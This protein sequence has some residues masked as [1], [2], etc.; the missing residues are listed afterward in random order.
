[1]IV[2]GRLIASDGQPS[3][4]SNADAQCSSNDTADTQIAN[5]GK[6]MLSKTDPVAQCSHQE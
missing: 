2:D 3:T 5:G 4:E 1:M 6:V